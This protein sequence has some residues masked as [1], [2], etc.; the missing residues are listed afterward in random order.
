VARARILAMHEPEGGRAYRMAELV[1]LERLHEERP[2]MRRVRSMMHD[3]LS[4]P[5]LGRVEAAKHVVGWFARADVP[6][7]AA[8]EVAGYALVRDA[9]MRYRLLA[10]ADPYR[11]AAIVRDAVM[12][13]ERTIALAER[14]GS[15]AWPKGQ[16]WN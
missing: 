4:R 15:D 8:I 10:E 2:P 5:R 3:L 12:D 11:R 9:E 13:L 16:S 6:V 14:Q 1:P 7:H